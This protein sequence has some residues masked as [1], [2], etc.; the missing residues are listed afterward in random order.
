M[1]IKN[2][3]EKRLI[4]MDGKYHTY[5]KFNSECYNRNEDV[6]IIVDNNIIGK[7]KIKNITNIHNYYSYHF[8]CK[9]SYYKKYGNDC[10]CDIILVSE[11]KDYIKELD[12]NELNKYKI[13][14]DKNVKGNNYRRKLINKLIN[15]DKKSTAK[16]DEDIRVQNICDH[17]NNKTELGLK[18]IKEYYELFDKEIEN[19]V[20]KGGK[21]IHFDM[22]IYHTDGTKYQCEEKGTDTYHVNINIGTVPWENSVEFYNGPANKFTISKKYLKLWYD[23]NVNNNTIKEKY[24]LPEIPE[25]IYWLE[26]SPYCMYDPKIEYSIILK[27]NFREI[28]GGESMGGHGKKN[29]DIDYRK[30]VNEKFKMEINETDEKLLI[31]EVQEIYDDV[32]NQKECW[33]QT[34]GNPQTNEFSFKWY[35]KIDPK[36]IKKVEIIDNPDILFKFILDDNNSFIGHMRWGK[37]CGFSCFR[38]DL[39]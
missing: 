28:N 23:T 13:Y 8:N 22:I 19:V 36:T 1:P 15:G 17:I 27:K 37:G 16:K 3:Y 18:L 6:Y 11:L 35:K 38:M 26:G 39:K 21:N 32:M 7:Y 30:Q 25:Y 20:K 9:I 34:T 12:K 5:I 24:N 31:K 29:T 2:G 4:N 33:L 14:F 10:C